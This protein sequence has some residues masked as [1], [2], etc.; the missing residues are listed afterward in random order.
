MAEILSECDSGDAGV[1]R[2]S[3]PGSSLNESPQ[4]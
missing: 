1:L 2:A 4:G 3:L